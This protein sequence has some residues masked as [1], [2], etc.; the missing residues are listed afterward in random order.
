MSDARGAWPYPR[1]VAHRGAGLLAP[2]N[3][4][5]ALRLGYA[6][7]LR[8]AEFDVKLSGDGV[9]F[10][11]HDDTLERTTNGT[12]RA[13]AFSWV[14]LSKL[15]AGSWHSSAFAG[16]PLPTLSS[17]ARWAIANGVACNVEIK[18]MPGRER[19]TGAAV[20][21]D[22]LTLWKGATPQP[23]LS[24]FSEVSLAAAQEAVPQLERALL[25]GRVPGDWKARLERL[26]CV[27]LDAK[28]RELDKALVGDAHDAGYRVLAYTPNERADIARMLEWGVDTVI[29]DAVDKALAVS[30]G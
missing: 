23:I 9:P 2:E 4:L 18:P 15:D 5:A 12:G 30:A 7:G 22:V 25:V 6:H 21:L 24:S 11:L 28:F 13:D 1:L 26:G 19:E 20:A 14:E 29:T 3:T 27:A 8:M 16:E 17:V 10:L